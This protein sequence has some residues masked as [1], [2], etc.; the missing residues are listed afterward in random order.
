[1][2][3]VSL[4]NEQAIKSACDMLSML[5]NTP[6]SKA[7]QHT[8]TKRLGLSPDHVQVILSKLEAINDENSDYCI[9]SISDESDGESLFVRNCGPINPLAPSA[10]D[11]RVLAEVLAE[12]A[13]ANEWKRHLEHMLSLSSGALDAPAREVEG[14]DPDYVKSTLM[15]AIDWGKRL[16]ILYRSGK[17]EKAT[18]RT[19][20]AK[21]VHGS[22]CDGTLYAWPRQDSHT[23]L[24]AEAPNVDG[25]EKSYR[26]NR[27]EKIEDTGESI[28]P[29]VDGSAES[30][31]KLAHI[32]AQD[33]HALNAMHLRRENLSI[34][35]D[36]SVE[37]DV[38]VY[39][40]GR[41]LFSAILSSNGSVE[42]LGPDIYQEGMA[43]FVHKLLAGR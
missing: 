29:A 18:W 41:R 40:D 33:E 35:N 9:V 12:R 8:V 20:D 32:R 6:M 28:S 16:R 7:S 5:S 10:D 36:G 13:E 11:A 1:M 27:I 3:K 23:D 15:N 25:N 38:H 2:P 4:T 30:H 14:F 21:E 34:G 39:D 19:V 37:A 31:V 42:L 43:A 24:P 26:L 22:A 17:E